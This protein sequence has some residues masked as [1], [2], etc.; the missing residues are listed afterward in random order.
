MKKGSKNKRNTKYDIDYVR[1]VFSDNGCVLLEENYKNCKTPMQYIAKCGH[2]AEISFDEVKNA[3]NITFKCIKCQKIKHYDLDEVRE[4]FKENGCE[5]ISDEYRTS[6]KKL[7]YIPMCGH[8]S[9]ISVEKFLNGQGRV[10]SKCAKPRGEK[11]HAYNPNLTEEHRQKRDMQNGENK[12]VR[13]K[14]F[15]RD[16]YTCQMCRDNSGGNL[17]A[18]HIDSW[19]I[20]IDKRFEIDNLVTL[21]KKCHK[22]F[23]MKYGYGNNTAKQFHAW[24]QVM[25]IPRA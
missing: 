17:E 12:K 11:H 7:L 6:K 22:D 8:E 14:A 3:K 15:E 21:C 25:R 2:M 9:S 4:I 1:Q 13:N 5:L 23:H 16:N 24:L 18:H 19:D 20:N 10:C